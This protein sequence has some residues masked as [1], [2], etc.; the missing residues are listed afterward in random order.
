MFEASEITIDIEVGLSASLGKLIHGEGDAAAS[1]RDQVADEAN[2]LLVQMGIPA[3]A[4]VTVQAANRNDQLRLLV[5]GK[6]VGCPAALLK[7][8]ARNHLGD[9]YDADAATADSSSLAAE[10]LLDELAARV[11]ADSAASFATEVAKAILRQRPYLLFNADACEALRKT[12]EDL[13]AEARGRPVEIPSELFERTVESSLGLSLSVTDVRTLASHVA[14]GAECNLTAEQ[15][16]ESLIACVRPKQIELLVEPEYGREVLGLEP[17]EPL[18]LGNPMVLQVLGMLAETLFTDLGFRRPPVVVVAEPDFSPGTF[19]F[20]INDLVGAAWVGPAADELFVN[21]TQAVLSALGIEGSLA[22]NPVDGRPYAFVHQRHADRLTQLQVDQLPAFG[23]LLLALMGELRTSAW[24]LLDVDAVEYELGMLSWSLEAV[25]GA[26]LESVTAERLTRILRDL[27]KQQLSLRHLPTVL[28]AVCLEDYVLGDL[29]AHVVVD[30]RLILDHR[31]E[32]DDRDPVDIS[33]QAVR[34]R[35]AYYLGYHYSGGTRT[36]RALQLDSATIEERIVEC[37]ARGEADATLPEVE[38]IRSQVRLELGNPEVVPNPP[39]IVTI[40][41]VASFLRRELH[42]E[43]PSLPVLAFQ[44]LPGDM[45]F[46]S[47][48]VIGRDE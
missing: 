46:D 1:L 39:V 17:G 7:R 13:V 23:Y 45:D 20:R 6:P 47:L 3:T 14:E 24:R 8:L 42:D 18:S 28:E 2:A 35:L 9:A 30:D 44:E 5:Q 34:K 33:V 11:D 31:I 26:A 43:F 36:L 12:A 10:P 37:L 27:L 16:S 4:T 38:R 25:T 40:G 21:A 15:V 48:G 41:P 32:A 19:A 29:S 22:T